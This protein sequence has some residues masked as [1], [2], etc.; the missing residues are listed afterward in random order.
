[1]QSNNT[2][3][4]LFCFQAPGLPDVNLAITSLELLAVTTLPT[5]TPVPF[6]PPHVMGICLW[7]ERVITLV[8]LA[9]ALGG[10]SQESAPLR[11]VVAQAAG[12]SRLDIIAWP[13]A[14]G[15]SYLDVPARCPR[16]TAPPHLRTDLLLDTIAAGEETICLLRL[17]R[18][19][20][21]P[22]METADREHP[23]FKDPS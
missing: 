6:A 13:L 1:M 8:D 23:L 19:A 22:H 2:A 16:V 7:R 5:P 4:S 17:E 12:P 21:E 20:A 11:Y 18:L 10:G 14:G 3:R 9:A 15:G